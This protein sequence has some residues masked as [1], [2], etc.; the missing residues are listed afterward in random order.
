MSYNPTPLTHG[1][2]VQV[3]SRN[4]WSKDTYWTRRKITFRFRCDPVPYINRCHGY[5][6]YRYPHTFQEIAYR[7][8]IR[9]DIDE[10]A[11]ATNHW[12]AKLKTQRNRFLPHA[13]DDIP[14]FCLKDRNWKRFRNTQYKASPI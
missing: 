1:T 4:W 14:R 10:G 9:H 6:G 2:L 7:Y 13:W 12:I 8:D 3:D 11:W 5:S